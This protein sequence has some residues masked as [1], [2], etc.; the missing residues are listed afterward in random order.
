MPEDM[1]KRLHY[2]DKQFLV[3][4]DFTDE[5]KYHLGMRRRHNRLLHTPGIAEGLEVQKT[6]AKTITISPGTALNGLGQEIVLFT[7]VVLSLDNP[8]VIS[9]T[10]GANTDI[11]VTIAYKE[12]ETDPQP[13]DKPLGNTRTTEQ[14]I[15]KIQTTPPTDNTVILIATFK[16]DGSGNI[17]GN[18]GDKF[19]NGPLPM[20]SNVVGVRVGVGTALS[21]NAVSIRKLKKQLVFDFV[22]GGSGITLAGG[23]TSQAFVAHKSPITSASSAFLLVYA[24]S[25]TSGARFEWRQEY[26]TVGTAPDFFTNQTVFFK[27]LITTAIEIRF[28]IYTVLES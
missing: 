27:N 9:P 6:A 14:A 2:F 20:P 26:S 10:P 3:E 17:P 4:A 1:I 15:A 24:F 11:Y 8:S 19:D 18:A 5:Q 21:D 7:S 13:T 22:T 16:L 23:A 12:S 28:R 25:V